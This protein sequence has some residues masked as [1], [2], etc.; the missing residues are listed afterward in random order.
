MKISHLWAKTP[1]S[2]PNAKITEINDTN[3][4]ILLANGKTKILNVMRIKK[5]F[6]SDN[7]DI[8]NKTVPGSGELNFNSKSEFTGP[9]TRAIKKLLEQQNA[10]NLAISVL[11]DLS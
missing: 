3:A 10:T 11:C 1:N 5:F 2:H 7:S 4:R 8:Q 9:V 6:K